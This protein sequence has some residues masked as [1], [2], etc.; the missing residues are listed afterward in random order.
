[1][2][3]LSECTLQREIAGSGIL[4]GAGIQVCIV[5][6]HCMC[7]SDVLCRHYSW[8]VLL[9]AIH[10]PHGGLKVMDAT[11]FLDCASPLR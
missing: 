1:M 11:L 6:T 10:M 3:R 9:Q 8:T 4:C 7:M 2:P 5:S